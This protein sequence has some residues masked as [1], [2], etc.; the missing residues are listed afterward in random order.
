[1]RRVGSA[2]RLGA[3]WAGAAILL[4]SALKALAQTPL[5]LV[6]VDAAKDGGVK[7]AGAIEVSNGHAI[8]GSSGSITAGD[9]TA[10]ISPRQGRAAAV[11][12]D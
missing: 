7:V 2:G 8:I 4:M 6:P 1:M 9:K 11:F 3:R 12:D 5:A 10:S